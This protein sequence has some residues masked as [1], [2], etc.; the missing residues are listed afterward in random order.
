MSDIKDLTTEQLEDEIKKRKAS[1]L[2]I[3]SDLKWWDII[4]LVLV[5]V[6]I[7][8]GMGLLCYFCLYSEGGNS[9]I[10]ILMSIGAWALT[11]VIILGI[12]RLEE[13]E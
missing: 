4:L 8:I 6:C 3:K 13:L 7:P 5:I 1:Q 12:F 10:R 2:D 11:E 9:D